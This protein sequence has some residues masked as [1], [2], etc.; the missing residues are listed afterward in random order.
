MKIWSIVKWV[1]IVTV[2]LTVAAACVFGYYILVI[3]PNEYR[4]KYREAITFAKSMGVA[5]MEK[6]IRDSSGVVE[7]KPYSV[8][9][10]SSVWTWDDEHG[11]PAEFKDIRPLR[12]EVNGSDVWYMTY[13]CFSDAVYVVVVNPKSDAPSVILRDGYT[14]DWKFVDLLLYERKPM[15]QKSSP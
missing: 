3:F 2:I 12:V 1:L 14:N 7:G 11:Y 15:Q 10:N 8:S 9:P 5:R 6:L 13:K 4:D